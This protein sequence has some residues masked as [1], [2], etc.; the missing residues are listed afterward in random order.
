M[1]FGVLFLCSAAT[2]SV[3]ESG[4]SWGGLWRP[5]RF[6]TS[7]PL[8]P[9][10]RVDSSF[11]SLWPKAF[12]H[13][14]GRLHLCSSG[15]ILRDQ[16]FPNTETY[17]RNRSV[18][19]CFVFYCRLRPPFSLVLWI[20]AYLQATKSDRRTSIFSLKILYE[21]SRRWMALSSWLKFLLV[22][23]SQWKGKYKQFVNCNS[24]SLIIF[25]LMFWMG[26][27]GRFFE[28][29]SGLM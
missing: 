19:A 5:C 8:F 23:L 9:D 21:N 22:L 12:E 29:A 7:W 27:F 20:E 15:K 25:M 11:N 2:S 18:L 28:R 13:I 24:W 17:S 16:K 4:G 3:G 1:P 10:Q 6:H 14:W 26:G